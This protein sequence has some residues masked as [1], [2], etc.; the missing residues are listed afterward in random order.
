MKPGSVVLSEM[1]RNPVGDYGVTLL[2]GKGGEATFLAAS[3]QMINKDNAWI[4]STI[5]YA[6]QERLKEKFE[7]IDILETKDIPKDGEQLQHNGISSVDGE[8]TAH[9]VVDLNVRT[10]GSLALP[11]LKGHFT[12]RGMTCASSFSTTAKGSRKEFMVEGGVRNWANADHGLDEKGLQD[13][14]K[15]VRESTEEVTF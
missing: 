12:S 2:V 11:L 14:M 13:L 10:S 9:Y 8:K 4:G 5:N 15:R 1:V 3:E 6:R 7:G